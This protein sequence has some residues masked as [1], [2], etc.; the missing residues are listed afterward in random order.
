MSKFL[1]FIL[2]HY[3]AKLEEAN[4]YQA[5]IK[6]KYIEFNNIITLPPYLWDGEKMLDFGFKINNISC[7]NKSLGSYKDAL[8]LLED[9]N[10]DFLSNS[11]Q[12]DSI[13]LSNGLFA[14]VNI[15]ITDY[16][17]EDKI[18]VLALSSG[19][20]NGQINDA[21]DYN[22]QIQRGALSYRWGKYIV[23][24]E[25]L[26]S[27]IGLSQFWES[28]KEVPEMLRSSE[29]SSKAIKAELEVQKTARNTN[30]FSYLINSDENYQDFYQN[31]VYQ[32]RFFKP[33]T[34]VYV[35]FNEDESDLNLVTHR[36]VLLA[37]NDPRLSLQKSDC[38][39]FTLSW[40][41]G[42]SATKQKVF[43]RAF[44]N[45]QGD[46]IYADSKEDIFHP[47]N[48]N[49]KIEKEKDMLELSINGKKVAQW[50]CQ[51]ASGLDSVA[52]VLY[53]NQKKMSETD[54]NMLDS[55]QVWNKVFVI[56]DIKAQGVDLEPFTFHLFS[57]YAH[58]FRKN[59]ASFAT[60]AEPIINAENS[61]IQMS[62]EI[63]VGAIGNIKILDSD[64]VEIWVKSKEFEKGKFSELANEV[65]LE[66]G[67]KYRVQ[68]ATGVGII[69]RAFE[70]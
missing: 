56:S 32:K 15:E 41:S 39:S 34:L 50:A 40:G 54:W 8:V 14:K 5:S 30:V 69:E 64:G 3:Q 63:N 38:Q 68:I 10:S 18:E 7:H 60:I 23:Q 26:H 31:L 62:Y 4:H 24:G 2:G 52:P 57:D 28:L 22:I 45:M 42:F 58:S 27:Y 13:E 67:K 46:I 37:D 35:A 1:H 70:F 6:V 21:D 44:K 53:D 19:I 55:F 11:L 25:R 17:K 48:Y 36:L 61:S 20:I 47:F 16:I 49:E 66:K 59:R 65:K 33:N 12:L 29:F 43:L 51:I 9:N